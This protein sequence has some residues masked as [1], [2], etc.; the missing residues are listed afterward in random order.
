VSRYIDEGVAGLGEG[1]LAGEQVTR[2]AT[3]SSAFK[4][5][6]CDNSAFKFEL[7]R[8]Q[9]PPALLYLGVQI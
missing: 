1:D 6:F 9:G 8:K 4:F 2:G 7:L 5:F 3:L